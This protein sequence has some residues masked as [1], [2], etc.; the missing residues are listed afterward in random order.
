MKTQTFATRLS[1]LPPSRQERLT[2][3]FRKA[4]QR[5]QAPASRWLD[6]EK[7]VG[8]YIC[9][10]KWVNIWEAIGP[11]LEVFLIVAPRIKAYL[12]NALEPISSRVTWSMYMIGR[13][14]NLASPSIMF[15]CEVPGHR[16]EARNTIKESGI[17][18]GYPG[19][20]TGDLPRPPGFVHELVDLGAG[21]QLGHNGV[22]M[23]GNMMALTSKGRSACGSEIF[24]GA[25]GGN[26]SS[27]SAAATIGGVIRIGESYYYT[28]AAHSLLPKPDPDASDKGLPAGDVHDPDEDAL[29][30]DGSDDRWSPSNSNPLAEDVKPRN[31]AGEI[32][33]DSDDNHYLKD[34]IL[35]QW[36]LKCHHEEEGPLPSLAKPE[37]QSLNPTGRLFMT[38]MDGGNQGAGLDYALIEMSPR[39]HVVENVIGV[40][41]S[42]RSI[43]RVHSVAKPTP[44]GMDI[45]A[46][47]PRGTTKGWTSGT[48]LYSSAPGKCSYVRMLKATLEG[49]LDRG[50]CGTWVVDATNG[51]LF[52]HI[53]LGSAGGGTALLI[54]FSDIFDDVRSRLGTSPTFP[55]SR[56]DENL[57]RSTERRT[58]SS[59][60]D[61][62][63]ARIIRKTISSIRE[64]PE[65]EG[66]NNTGNFRWLS[67]IGSESQIE[68]LS[69]VPRVKVQSEGSAKEVLSD[70]GSETKMLGN[71]ER[72]DTKIISTRYARSERG[73]RADSDTKDWVSHE[74]RR[75]VAEKIL[76]SSR[77]PEESRESYEAGLEDTSNF[78]RDPGRQRSS[79]AQTSRPS[80]DAAL[81]DRPIETPPPPRDPKFRHV[82]F[83]FSNAPM[84]WENTELLDHALAQIDLGTIISEAEQENQRFI[85]QAQS[86]GEAAKPEWGYQDC[87]IRAL[88]RYFGQSFFTRIK[89]PSCQACPSKLPT[90]RRGKVQPTPEEKA[91]RAEVVEL[92]QC[93][94]QDCQAY[95][96]FPRYWDV[97][98]LLSNPRGRAGE[99]ANC[100]GVLCRALGSRARWVWNAEDGIWTEVYS[101][102]Q[103]RW[104]HVDPCEGAWDNPLLYT[105]TMG[106]KMSYCIAFSSDG[107]TDVTRR[108]VRRSSHA[109]GRTRCPEPELLRIIYDIRS[110]RRKDLSKEDL[111]RLE[112]EDT[113]EAQELDSYAV[114][115]D[116]MG[117]AGH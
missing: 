91:G 13:A 15:F 47:T 89:K 113:A 70:M 108:Y 88:S 90:I 114:P 52:G 103:G 17:L 24:V 117:T 115:S 96:R 29:S 68:R 39:H 18:N 64:S 77:K 78:P 53:V 3:I 35:R 85:S 46:V 82:L 86:K 67:P 72:D 2:A 110:K 25:N 98:T 10:D 44:L 107:A 80:S 26:S 73:S 27:L 42:N 50:D 105:E 112:R 97:K 28:T 94:E 104:I 93:A 4:Q 40:G 19:I 111:T 32:I 34:E 1:T 71:A 65:A 87:M 95:T 84:K 21:E 31:S 16:R 41:S 14:P 69:E 81:P 62:V 102:H 56:D 54:P 9:K 23:I 75:L 74:F 43:V 5:V 116:M 79:G 99:S 8:H 38:S 61:E 45:V 106:K 33:D 100:F 11:A 55:T 30:L 92:Y 7:S 51:D 63:L 76:K 83:T 48:P 6:P 22:E 49:P 20:K 66:N 58:L 36:S 37:E 12:D 101:E 109:L 57:S 59:T 60:R